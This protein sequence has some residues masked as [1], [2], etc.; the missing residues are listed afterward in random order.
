MSKKPCKWCAEGRVP[1]NGEHWI[2]KGIDR[3]DIRKCTNP[4]PAEGENETYEQAMLRE[5]GMPSEQP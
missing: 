1:E 3:I 2:V 5:V 4:A